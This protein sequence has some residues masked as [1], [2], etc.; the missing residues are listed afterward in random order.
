MANVVSAEPCDMKA[1]LPEQ[2]TL[3]LTTLMALISSDFQE[4]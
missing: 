4:I 3:P 2:S 1:N